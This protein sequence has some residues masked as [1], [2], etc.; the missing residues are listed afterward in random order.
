[1]DTDAPADVKLAYSHKVKNDVLWW[2]KGNKPWRQCTIL[3]TIKLEKDIIIL[4]NVTKFNKIVIKITVRIH[5]TLSK[6]WFF[7][8]KGNNS[9]RHGT[10]WT[11]I[12]LE[13]DIMVPDNV[14]KFH[15]DREFGMSLNLHP[16]FV[17]GSREGSD[18][19]CLSDQGMYR[20]ICYFLV[21][22]SNMNRFSHDGAANYWIKI[23]KNIYTINEPRY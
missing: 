1:M 13:E 21:C 4:N 15:K 3:T 7:I 9:W 2:T 14:T 19:R 20:L 18:Q 10:I 12:K 22:K 11:I 6:W 16:F 17:C 23:M 8:K 5:Q